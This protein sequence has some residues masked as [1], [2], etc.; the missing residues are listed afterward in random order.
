MA[1]SQLIRTMLDRGKLRVDAST[2]LFDSLFR[3]WAA[4]Q[5]NY[6]DKIGNAASTHTVRNE[7]KTAYELTVLLG[8]K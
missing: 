7:S 3:D 4:E 8:K 6:T 5:T 1:V 2:H